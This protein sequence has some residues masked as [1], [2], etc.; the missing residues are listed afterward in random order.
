[1]CIVE[2]STA[3]RAL[4]GVVGMASAGAAG[5]FESISE[6]PPAVAGH[7]PVVIAPAGRIGVKVGCLD[8]VPGQ[9]LAETR[10]AVPIQSAPGVE[11]VVVVDVVVV[12]AG[13][14]V[15]CDVYR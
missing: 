14:G 10:T 4:A 9:L 15:P 12:S 13:H 3:Y 8:D 2:P 6:H 5:F 1:M 11:G 7:N